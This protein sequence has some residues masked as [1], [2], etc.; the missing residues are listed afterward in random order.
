V[1]RVEGN[2]YQVLRPGVVPARTLQR[3]SSLMILLVCTGNTCRS[4]MGELLCRDM[5]ARRVGCKSDELEENGVIVMSA[6]IATMMGGGAARE[7]VQAMA[8]LGLDLS[9]HQTQPL[10]EPLVRHADLIYAM[11]ASHRS[12]IVAQWPEAAQR[13]HLLCSDGCDISDPIGGPLERYRQ[14]AAEI[15]SELKT[16]LDN[17]DL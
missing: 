12:M 3:L 6:G 8:E 16:R 17:L 4:P 11:T 2:R 13:T 7:A 15:R 9:G 10:N 5:L 1:V 14:C